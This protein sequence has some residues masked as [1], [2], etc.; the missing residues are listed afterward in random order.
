MLYFCL[1]VSFQFPL[2][3]ASGSKAMYR[4]VS[5][6]RCSQPCRDAWRFWP[7]DRA[8]ALEGAMLLGGRTSSCVLSRTPQFFFLLSLSSR[9]LQ[10][11]TPLLLLATRRLQNHCSPGVSSRKSSGTWSRFLSRGRKICKKGRRHAVR[12]R[13]TYSLSSNEVRIQALNLHSLASLN[14]L[15]WMRIR[16][17]LFRKRWKCFWTKQIQVQILF[18]WADLM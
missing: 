1:N 6:F 12:K 13:W 15:C 9:D 10:V 17:N 5:R 18:W 2:S 3:L 7:N 4:L 8:P 16:G 11:R 14:F